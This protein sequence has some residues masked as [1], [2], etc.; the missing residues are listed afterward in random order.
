VQAATLDDEELRWLQLADS[1]VRGERGRDIAEGEIRIDR[2]RTPFAADP[3]VVQQRADL[4]REDDAMPVQQREEQRPHPK[5]IARHDETPRRL[6]PECKGKRPPEPLGAL[7][8]P[9]FVGV[10]DELRIGRAPELVTGALELRTQLA[11]VGQ[12]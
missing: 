4:R 9:L 12:L 5:M 8:A 1:A 7:N 10:R 6:V 2:G 3:R 11:G